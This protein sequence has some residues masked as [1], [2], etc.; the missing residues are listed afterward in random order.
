VQIID[1]Q[2]HIWAEN[3]PERPWAPNM[4]GRAHLAEP[5]SAER[6]LGMMDQAGV[7]AAILVPPSLE[8]NRNDL[9]L[10]AARKFSDRFAV[11]GRIDLANPASRAALA[12]WRDQPG[13]LGLRLT[14]HRPDTRPQLT[15]GT[16]DWLWPAAEAHGI[17]LMVHAPAGLPRLA[18]IAERHPRLTIIVDHMGFG[19]ETT[20]ANALA[21]A[22]RV[23]ALAH[24]RNVFVKVSAL[25]CFSSEPYPFRNLNQPL[26]D[27]IAA[28]GPRRCFWGTDLSRTLE[29]CSYRQGV[30]HFTEELDFLSADDLDWIM[31]RGLR[32]CLRWNVGKP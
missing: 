16:A 17:P 11:M 28:F 5:L 13:M 15:D 30:T 4:E 7:D 20:D 21:G 14:F 6:L 23:A 31:G 8:G 18:E 12:T 1:S 27:V 3:T 19:R 22:A 29:H 10:A 9:A 26:R 25:P 32:E 2:V 24:C